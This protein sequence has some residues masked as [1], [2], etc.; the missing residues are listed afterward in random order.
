MVNK[1]N[2]RRLYTKTELLGALMRAGQFVHVSK[3]ALERK[4]SNLYLPLHRDFNRS[5]N[6]GL[7]EAVPD[8]LWEAWHS[9]F[10]TEQVY[11][12]VGTVSAFSQAFGELCPI[13]LNI[14]RGW[15]WHDEDYD[16]ISL[17][18]DY[19]FVPTPAISIDKRW[20]GPIC[21]KCQNGIWKARK[22]KPEDRFDYINDDTLNAAIAVIMMK[23]TFKKR[24]REGPSLRFDPRV[25]RS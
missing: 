23:P 6:M 24:V 9:G 19:L 16:A 25:K 22:G 14:G 12:P 13:C 18:P 3:L 20:R 5:T 7:H 2:Y 21:E 17:M 8:G 10:L 4:L 11:M 15:G 1:L